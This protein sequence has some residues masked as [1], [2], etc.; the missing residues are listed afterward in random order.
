MTLIEKILLIA[1]GIEIVV[2]LVLG[3]FNKDDND[4]LS[5]L[6]DC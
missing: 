6:E 2:T 5:F 4:D 1:L 3:F